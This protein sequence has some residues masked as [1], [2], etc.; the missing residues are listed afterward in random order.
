MNCKTLVHI[1]GAATLVAGS[2]CSATPQ[3]ATVDSEV[4]LDTLEQLLLK[5]GGFRLISPPRDDI[6]PGLIF[7]WEPCAIFTW[8]KDYLDE[9]YV[10]APPSKA[11]W[12]QHWVEK[13]GSAAALMLLATISGS[14][15]SE[16]EIK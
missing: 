12:L 3:T 6:Q 7:E 14:N 11:A 10:P 2:G 13:S 5:N 4:A 8:P 9:N 1:L 15:A 16:S